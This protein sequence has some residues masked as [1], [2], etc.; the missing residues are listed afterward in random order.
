M[1]RDILNLAYKLY[2]RLYL[3]FGA[4]IVHRYDPEMLL[5]FT[6]KIEQT[7]YAV[8]LSFTG[9]WRGTNRQRLYNELGWDSL[10][11]RRWYHRLRHFVNLKDRQ[12]VE[13]L[14]SKIAIKRHMNYNLRRVHTYT[15]SC[16]RTTR[17]SNTYFSNVLSMS[18]PCL[19]VILGA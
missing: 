2:V 3:H 16:G 9:A 15:P 8:A 17:F 18:G 6:Q 1:S 4:I 19:I 10:Y 14:F 12:S 13:Y 5:G 11:S 7:Q